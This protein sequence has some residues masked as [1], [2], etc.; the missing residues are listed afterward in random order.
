MGVAVKVSDHRKKK[1][2]IKTNDAEATLAARKHARAH[3]P[4]TATRRLPMAR[5]KTREHNT[6]HAKKKKIKGKN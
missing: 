5:A 1:K 6:Q 3:K 2:K 4:K